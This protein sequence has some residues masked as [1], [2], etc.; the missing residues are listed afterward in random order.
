MRETNVVSVHSDDLFVTVVIEEKQALIGKSRLM[1][2]VSAAI[3]PSAAGASIA[4][5]PSQWRVR[6]NQKS[7]NEH[8]SSTRAG[9]L[10]A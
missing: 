6:D 5:R 2:M 9:I 10:R 7:A 8:T 3:R 1:M 4:V